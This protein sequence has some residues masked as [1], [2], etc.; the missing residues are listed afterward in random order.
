MPT[1]G[2]INGTP[3]YRVLC[4]GARGWRD[5]NTMVAAVEDVAV[6]IRRSG[7]LAIFVH[8]AC[9]DGADNMLDKYCRTMGNFAVETHPADWSKGKQAGHDRNQLMVD[10]GA[11]FCLAFCMF[12]EKP[13]CPPQHHLTHGTRDCSRRAESANIPV[14]YIWSKTKMEGLF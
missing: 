6:T 9:P 4:T 7:G 11:D 13:E 14:Q 8:G 12:C 1:P 10:L 2:K 5:L 3:I